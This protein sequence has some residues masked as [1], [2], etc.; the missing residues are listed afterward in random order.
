MPSIALL[1]AVFGVALTSVGGGGASGADETTAAP[2]STSAA[3][4]RAGGKVLARLDKIKGSLRSTEY[5]HTTSVRRKIGHYAWDCS[6]MANWILKRDAPRAFEALHRDRPVARTYWRTIDKA[7]TAK[8]RRGWQKIADITD[9]RPGDVFAWRRP[10]DWP[11]GGNTGHVGF[12]VGSPETVTDERFA[13]VRAF[14]VR[15]IDAT[16]LP[17]QDDTRKPEGK[18]GFGSGTL[19]FVTDET[20]RAYAY[21]WFGA[22][23]RG[24]IPTDIVFGRLTG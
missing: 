23:S 13:A 4:T 8:P 5:R 24:V 10:P 11:P 15:I 16:S 14:T 12:V 3:Q 22:R 2:A 1:G 21:G 18:G 6:G 20:G 17:H 19:L 7:P 9:V